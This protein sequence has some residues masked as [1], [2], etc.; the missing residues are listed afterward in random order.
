MRLHE[1]SRATLSVTG[2]VITDK[3][4]FDKLA[5]LPEVDEPVEMVNL[6]LDNGVIV[7]FNTADSPLGIPVKKAAPKHWPPQDG[8][9]WQNGPE[10]WYAA[11][12]DFGHRQGLRLKK[13]EPLGEV[14]RSSKW[15]LETVKS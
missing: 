9:V 12:M 5:S 13:Y 7:R 8:D 2:T 1:G 10:A 11:M 6:E 3:D 15:L 4:F 14:I